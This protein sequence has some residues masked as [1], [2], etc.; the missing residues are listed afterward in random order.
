VSWA[1]HQFEVY[2]VHA[3]LPKKMRGKVSFWGVWLGDFTPDFLSKFWVYGITIN[4]TH[5]GATV[6][7]RWH[8]GWPGMGPTHTLFLGTVIAV[9]LWLWRRDR[10]LVVGYVLGYAAH[11][12]TDVNDSV[13]TMLLFPFSTLNWSLRTWAYAATVKGGKYLD[14]AA[15][16]SSL[17][18]AMDAFWLCVVLA[19]PRVLSRD[20]WRT[21][22][23]PSDPHIWSWL[24]KRLPERSLLALYRATF[25]YG[26]TRMIAWSFWAHVLAR[27]EIAGVLRRGYPFDLSWTGP[28][29]IA[30]RSLP[31][32][33]PWLV[34]PCTLAV[35]A[36]VYVVASALWDPMGRRERR[37]RA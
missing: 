5:Y 32:V 11:A 14:A 16:Y 7:Q 22:I 24:G 20:Y 31:H 29:W 8:R 1:A 37:L 2:A 10:A 30:A 26:A 18:L 21:R 28:W 3:H 27:P 19:T 15:Y 33:N 4:G 34:L 9:M 36:G 12:L 6:P 23:V 35:L 13:G 17:G 25:F